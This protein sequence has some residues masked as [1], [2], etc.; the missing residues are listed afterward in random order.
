MFAKTAQKISQFVPKSQANNGKVNEQHTVEQNGFF[1][2]MIALTRIII[3]RTV[4]VLVKTHQN[5]NVFVRSRLEFG[6]IRLGQ[7]GIFICLRIIY[8][9]L[10]NKV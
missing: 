10:I 6:Q 2:K 4:I 9:L 8:A 5:D 1:L 3:H 7:T